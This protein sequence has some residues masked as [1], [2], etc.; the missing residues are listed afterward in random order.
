MQEAPRSSDPC[1]IAARDLPRQYGAYTTEVD[2]LAIRYL[3]RSHEWPDYVHRCPLA[4]CAG[5][6]DLGG[7]GY[8]PFRERQM[9]ELF[10]EGR[11]YQQTTR[12]QQMVQ[13]LATLGR[14]RHPRCTSL[15]EIDRYFGRLIGLYETIK[16]DGY[17]RRGEGQTSEGEIT[18]RID[19]EGGFIKCGQGTHRLAIARLLCLPRVPVVV[20]LVH[21]YWARDWALRLGVPVRLAVERQL[22][23]IAIGASRPSGPP[24]DG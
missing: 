22:V 5:D 11:P 8:R 20:D 18:I 24:T 4:A 1:S 23:A 14:T 19:R 7:A 3:R 2:P 15:A 10:V 9:Q 12:Y 6:W 17:Q 13:D 21:W 16:C